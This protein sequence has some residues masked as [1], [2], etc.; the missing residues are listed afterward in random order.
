[1]KMDLE[2]KGT[3]LFSQARS[4]YEAA[5]R[6]VDPAWL[7]GET[8]S[9]EG[10]LVRISGET[11]DLGAFEN[12]RLIAFGKAAAGMAETLTGILGD[13]LTEGLVI[14]PAPGN[15]KRSAETQGA[16]GGA[17]AFR[18]NSKLEYLESSHPL[19]DERSIEAAR[20]ALDLAAG[21]GEKDLVLICVSG[22][23]SSLLCLPAGGITFDEKKAVTRDLLRSGA[24][25]RELNTVRKHLSGI[26]GGRLA[27]AAFPAT[28]VNLVISDV[29]GDD[30]ETIASGP[31][32]WDSSTFADA[33]AVLEKRRLWD[34]SPESV[35][36]LIEK[37]IRGEAG[38][39]LK[40]NDPAFAKVRTFI[41]GNTLAALQGARREA[42][43]LGF[44]PFILTASDEGEAR[45]AAHDYVAFMAGQ[46]CSMSTAPEPLCFLA[47]G[48]LTVT[49]KGQ[50][51][52]G[53]NMEFVLAA[54]LEMRE[55]GLGSMFCGTCEPP[56]DG[57]GQGGRRPFDWLVLSIGTDGIDGPT[58]A[59]G[60]WAGA[61]TLD[62]AGE[63]GLEAKRYLDDNDSYNFFKK[64]G[65]LIITEPTGTNVCDV[66][67]F[68]IVPR[69][70]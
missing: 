28:V 5:L 68:L 54:L 49:V 51:I 50:G 19:P 58:D 69:P 57:E 66:R 65:N 56:A 8:V 25:I 37:G 4:I 44:E 36:R 35:R 70:A 16:R 10:D 11:F 21:A 34:G 2:N 22:G 40:E 17:G 61:S 38:E 20:R 31:A 63:L 41:I 47:G 53:R 1:M 59:A 27:K 7:I 43:R 42:E 29:V 67:I 45:K 12:V 60:A 64:T 62:R 48:E 30:L 24:T 33:R 3:T 23:G 9:R 18:R 39:T 14:V 26:K 6:A 52:G 32:Y 55:E 15:S 13:R 46:A